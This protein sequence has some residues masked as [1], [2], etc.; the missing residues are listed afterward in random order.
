M[1]KK[2]EKQRRKH[3][4]LFWKYGGCYNNQSQKT[5]TPCDYTSCALSQPIF[6]WAPNGVWPDR[7]CKI[8]LVVRESS[9]S[10]VRHTQ[11]V[12]SVSTSNLLIDWET[13]NGMQAERPSQAMDQQYWA[14]ANFFFTAEPIYGVHVIVPLCQTLY[15]ELTL[16][17]SPKV[18]TPLHDWKLRGSAMGVLAEGKLP[19]P[20]TKPDDKMIIREDSRSDY[21]VRNRCWCIP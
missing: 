13:L 19:P 16:W 5:T 8:V 6:G 14:K 17:C 18:W 7:Q 10:R 15:F 1:K 12:W 21:Q 4:G 20:Y 9:H 2:E 3:S 11:T